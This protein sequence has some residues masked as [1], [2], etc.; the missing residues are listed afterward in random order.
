[1]LSSSQTDLVLM[2]LHPAKTYNLRMF[3]A[4]IVGRS[5]ASNVVTLT[6]KEAGKAT[7]RLTFWVESSHFLKAGLLL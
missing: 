3:A 5:G 2:D 6:T 4:N 7:S 1:M